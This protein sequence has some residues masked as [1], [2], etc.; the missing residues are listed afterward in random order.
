M[1]KFNK[2]LSKSVFLPITS[3]MIMTLLII[4]ELA[5][6]V[7][8]SEDVEEYFTKLVDEFSRVA[9][10]PVIKG[11]NTNR[12]HKVFIGSLRRFQPIYSYVRTNSK[13][14]VI[15][16]VIRGR[17]PETDHRSLANKPW[18]KYVKQRM[19]NRQGIIKQEETG[20]YYLFWTEPMVTKKNK[21]LGT[22]SVKVDLWDCF[23]NLSKKI[24]DPFLIRMGK[25]SFYSHK[26]EKGTAFKLETLSIPG[27][28]RMTIRYPKTAVSESE[29][30]IEET[31]SAP[32]V[33]TA[34]LQPAIAETTSQSATDTISS[35]ASE[36]EAEPKKKSTFLS[37]RIFI[38]ICVVLFLI[39]AAL[40][41]RLVM[42][43]RHKMLM[44]KIDRDDTI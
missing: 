14:V 2:L 40:V 5:A 28:G 35:I 29:P 1:V 41:T 43:A 38:I 16:E 19:Q 7:G 15:A 32:E 30:E 27:A 10:T 6:N 18:F 25:K 11:T 42:M 33:D 12:M 37:P 36:S 26:W 8:Y 13:G 20:R 24:E 22:L 31:T 21:F 39:L 3:S 9:K 34:S 23:H 44:K 17:K 4:G